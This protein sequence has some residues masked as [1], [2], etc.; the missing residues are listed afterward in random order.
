MDPDRTEGPEP[1]KTAGAG[2]R[3][4]DVD[5]LRAIAI[6]FL[7]VFHVLL[8]F[9]AWAS[10]VGFPQNDDLLEGFVPLISMLTVWRIPLLFMISGMG[11]RFAME[12]RD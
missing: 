10:S 5:W 6:G 2:P 4:H 8:S 7:I 11:V 12:R 1:G 3:R 9:Q